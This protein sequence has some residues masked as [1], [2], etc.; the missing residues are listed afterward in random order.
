MIRIHIVRIPYVPLESRVRRDPHNRVKSA[1][2]QFL[3][4]NILMLSHMLASEYSYRC[5]CRVHEGILAVWPVLSYV[6]V[7]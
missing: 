1:P 4:R 3:S 7:A 5:E 2:T 6:T